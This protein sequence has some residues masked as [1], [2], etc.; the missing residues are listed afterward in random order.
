MSRCATLRHGC[1]ES[2]VATFYS[3]SCTF[4]S[5]HSHPGFRRLDEAA[6]LLEQGAGGCAFA[7]ERFDPV[8]PGQHRAS[9]VHADEASPLQRACV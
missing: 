2:C 9:L 8:E 6:Q 5:F 1:G 7:F 4:V 3:C